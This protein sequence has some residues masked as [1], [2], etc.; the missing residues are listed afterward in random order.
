MMRGTTNFAG[1]VAGDLMAGEEVNWGK[2][3]LAGGTAALMSA[4]T[5]ATGAQHGR[6]GPLKVL[7]SAKKNINAQGEKCKY[8]LKSINKKIKTTRGQIA[9]SSIP[10][11]IIGRIKSFEFDV[12]HSLAFS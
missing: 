7:K 10:S 5:K 1:S 2:A 4:K 3:I 8:A 11:I 12:Y 6:T 9:K